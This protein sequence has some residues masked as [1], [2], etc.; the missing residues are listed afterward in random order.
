MVLHTGIFMAVLV[1][2]KITY[3]REAASFSNHLQITT[4]PTCSRLNNK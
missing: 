2:I 1:L 4:F 3:F